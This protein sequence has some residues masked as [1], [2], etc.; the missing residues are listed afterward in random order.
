MT[1][2]ID[3]HPVVLVDTREQCPLMIQRFPVER[4]TLPFGDYSL[5]GFHDLNN[6]GIIF[7]RK[8]VPDLIGSLTAGRERFLREVEGL[9]RF[10]FAAIVIEGE[11]ADVAAG[12]FRSKANPD[13]VLASLEAVEVRAGVHV[14]WCGDPVGAA[15]TVERLVRQYV[16]GL[17][18]QVT[19]MLPSGFRLEVAGDG[20]RRGAKGVEVIFPDGQTIEDVRAGVVAG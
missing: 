4:A 7:E 6:P 14:L 12:N 19:P 3:L 10:R 8:S 9:R 15:S 17:V 13:A 20:D 16:R 18:K 1:M 11:Q 2:R 5:K